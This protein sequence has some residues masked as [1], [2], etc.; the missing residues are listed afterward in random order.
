MAQYPPGSTFKL[1]NALIGLQEKTIYGGSKYKCLGGFNFGV[2]NRK[3]G[4]HEHRSP[5]NLKE[6]I[7]TSCNAYFFM[8]TRVL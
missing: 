8:S 5:L 6:A 7:A 3:M 4:C 2:E 1:V